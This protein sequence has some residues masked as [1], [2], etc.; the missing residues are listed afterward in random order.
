MAEEM[1]ERKRAKLNELIEAKKEELTPYDE[2]GI[3]SK[4]T[5]RKASKLR[6]E[7]KA[8]REK[9]GKA[10]KVPSLRRK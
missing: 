7:L 3:T 6:K 8:L 4:Y 10:C 2:A 1:Q 9:L 5:D